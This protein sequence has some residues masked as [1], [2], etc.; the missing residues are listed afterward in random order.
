MLYTIDC[1]LEVTESKFG[2]L[3]WAVIRSKCSSTANSTLKTIIS[4]RFNPIEATWCWMRQFSSF[5]MKTL[6]ASIYGLKSDFNIFQG[7]NAL[8][9]RIYTSSPGFSLTWW[10][11]MLKNRLLWN[12]IQNKFSTPQE[13]VSSAQTSVTW[14]RVPKNF[15]H[16]LHSAQPKRN[17]WVS[18]QILVLLLSTVQSRHF[19]RQWY[20]KYS[21]I[22]TYREILLFAVAIARDTKYPHTSS[23]HYCGTF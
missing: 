3:S 7:Y 16:L 22:S 17:L 21:A 9:W 8:I 13:L 12:L 4:A 5:Q 11:I 14:K 2:S 15:L 1:W 18:S 23:L 19:L 20:L 10:Y 6:S